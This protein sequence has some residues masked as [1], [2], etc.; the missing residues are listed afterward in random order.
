MASED[1][2]RR[3]LDGA[4]WRPLYAERDKNGQWN[5]YSDANGT[6]VALFPH[7]CVQSLEKESKANCRLHRVAVNYFPHLLPYLECAAGE[8]DEEAEA[9]LSKIREECRDGE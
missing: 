3:L 5:L 7:Q 9:M 2:I 4:T 1:P 8:G 6:W